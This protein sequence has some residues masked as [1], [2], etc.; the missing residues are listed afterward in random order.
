MI[1]YHT[2]EGLEKLQQ[3][4]DKFM[5][6]KGIGKTKVIDEKSM[7][8]LGSAKKEKNGYTQFSSVIL[9]VR[10]LVIHKDIFSVKHDVVKSKPF[11]SVEELATY[12]ENITYDDLVDFEVLDS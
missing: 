7:I 2:E 12:L 5:I 9:N 1:H 6:E 4:I 11:N 8:I 3:V 10:D